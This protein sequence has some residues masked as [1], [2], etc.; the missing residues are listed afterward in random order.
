LYIDKARYC[1]AFGKK[2]LI[3]NAG[4]PPKETVSKKTDCSVNELVFY[5]DLLSHR[6]PYC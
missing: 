6:R 5:L 4:R 1:A 2:I 3:N